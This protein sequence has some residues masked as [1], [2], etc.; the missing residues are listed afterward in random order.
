MES[1]SVTTAT[2][3]LQIVVHVCTVAFAAEEVSFR[4]KQL[5]ITTICSVFP[6]SHD[7]IDN[8]R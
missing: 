1:L 7:V 8:L 6:C 4:L 3:T 5:A 2:Y